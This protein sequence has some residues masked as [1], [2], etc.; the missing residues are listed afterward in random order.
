[1]Q[2]R[3]LWPIASGQSRGGIFRSDVYC[4][5]YNAMPWHKNP[6]AHATMLRSEQY[7]L[8]AIHGL[9]EGELY[10]L[11]KDPGETINL[12]HNP[13]YQAIKLQ[14]YMALCDRMAWTVD[15]LPKREAAW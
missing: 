5:Y 12:W 8:V 1:M 15:P 3:S 7:K 11:E 2:A 10:D 14:M 4:E 6:A 13:E 9:N